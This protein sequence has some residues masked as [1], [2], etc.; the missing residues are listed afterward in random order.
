MLDSGDFLR[1]WRWVKSAF[2][3]LSD[4]LDK[5]AVVVADAHSEANFVIPV[6]LEALESCLNLLDLGV[7]GQ[8][9]LENKMNSISGHS[10]TLR[11]QDPLAILIEANKGQA[12]SWQVE[13]V[14][15]LEFV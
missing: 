4:L 2:V 14:E 13:H 12:F 9:V 8:V 7:Y 5:G 6:G 1:A 11:H 3:L 10:A 15:L